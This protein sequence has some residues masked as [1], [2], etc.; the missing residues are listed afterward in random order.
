MVEIKN[1]YVKKIKGGKE[2]RVNLITGPAI[3][4][5]AATITK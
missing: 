1:R 2:G 4:Q 5:M 3:P